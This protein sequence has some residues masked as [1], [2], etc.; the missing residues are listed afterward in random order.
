MQNPGTEIQ[1]THHH[2]ASM[3]CKDMTRA[4]ASFDGVHTAIMAEYEQIAR[5]SQLAHH[6]DRISAVKF[7]GKSPQFKEQRCHSA[8]KPPATDEAPSRFSS[9]KQRRGKREKAQKATSL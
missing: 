2:I 8:P 3:Y 4:R 5:P 6:A 7:K 9:K 1:T